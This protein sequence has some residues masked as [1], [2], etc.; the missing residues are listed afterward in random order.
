MVLLEIHHQMFHHIHLGLFFYTYLFWYFLFLTYFLALVFY[1]Q[2]LLLLTSHLFSIHLLVHVVFHHSM[3]ILYMLGLYFL[4]MNLLFEYLYSH[5]SFLRHIILLPSLR[6]SPLILHSIHSLF[7]Y[8]V[9]HIVSH[10]YLL[11]LGIFHCILLHLLY[12][13]LIV[14]KS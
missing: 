3:N 10:H 1:V 4:L 5:H 14:Q 9:L 7:L 13:N 2:N 8:I 6:P 12:R 11:G